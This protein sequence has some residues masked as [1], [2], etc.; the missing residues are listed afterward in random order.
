MSAHAAMVIERNLVQMCAAVMSWKPQSAAP[1]I[2]E[3]PE[4]ALLYKGK[5]NVL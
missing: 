4:S 3:V 1:P 2:I 5:E